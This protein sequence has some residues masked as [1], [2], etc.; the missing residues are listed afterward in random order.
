MQACEQFS[1]MVLL[2]FLT[3]SIISLFKCST[4]DVALNVRIS[5]EDKQIPSPFDA[6]NSNSAE[7]SKYFSLS[8]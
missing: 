7:Q 4:E 6:R 2:T 1:C 5:V 3:D 8:F